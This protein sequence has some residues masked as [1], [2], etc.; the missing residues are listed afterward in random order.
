MITLLHRHVPT[1]CAC[2]A[3]ASQC[4]VALTDWILEAVL[5][6]IGEP[7]MWE[8]MERLARARMGQER[9]EAKKRWR[10]VQETKPVLRLVQKL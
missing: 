5:A 2:L 8:D 6:R 3:W 10:A 4:V 7:M 1:L 9:W